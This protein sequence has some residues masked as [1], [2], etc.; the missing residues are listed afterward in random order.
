[1]STR[2]FGPRLSAADGVDKKFATQLIRC[3]LINGGLRCQLFYLAPGS[4]GAC[5]SH[6]GLDDKG[7][8]ISILTAVSTAAGWCAPATTLAD[9][10]RRSGVREFI[11]KFAALPRCIASS[12]TP[13]W[14]AVSLEILEMTELFEGRVFSALNVA[15][16][17]PHPDIFLHAA[18][19]IGVSPRE[20]IIIEDSAS[21]VIAGREAGSTVIGLLAAGHIRDGHGARLKDAGAHY[22]A[23][24]YVEVERIVRDLLS[25]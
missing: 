22:L 10:R 21:G 12:S 14:L 4:R 24:D 18:A 1:L 2:A 23:A 11:A 9:W 16:G 20:C 6:K 3:D 25:G 7:P 19:E 8:H 15:R 5:T 13:Q 17:K